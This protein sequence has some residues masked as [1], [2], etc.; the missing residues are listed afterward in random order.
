M[1]DETTGQ[2]PPPGIFNAPGAVMALIA[3]MAAIHLALYLAGDDWLAI[4]FAGFAFIPAQVSGAMAPWIAGAPVW[5]FLSHAFLHS[6]WT[7]LLFNCLWLLVF[8]TVVARRM[9]GWR[10]L[11]V[12]LISALGGALATLALHWGVVMYLIGASGGVSGLL[13][14]A[15]PVMYGDKPGDAHFHEGVT[16]ARALSP[17]ELVTSRRALVFMAIWLALTLISGSSGLLIPGQP[18]NIAWEAHLGGFV[19]GLFAFYLLD[20]GPSRAA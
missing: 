10:L 2:T 9:G 20:R 16:R 3:A 6:G 17:L 4:A 1:T 15:I 8:G 7:H 12:F 13:A 11:A 14:A 5:S 18:Q 19:A